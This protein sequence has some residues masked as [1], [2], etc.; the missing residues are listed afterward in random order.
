L[1]NPSGQNVLMKDISNIS[2][3][4]TSLFVYIDHLQTLMNQA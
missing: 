4:G 2:I 3:E 1:I